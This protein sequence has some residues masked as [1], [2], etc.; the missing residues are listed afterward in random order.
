MYGIIFRCISVKRLKRDSRRACADRHFSTSAKMAD[1]DGSSPRRKSSESDRIHDQLA[2]MMNEI[3]SLKTQVNNQNVNDVNNRPAIEDGEVEDAGDGDFQDELHPPLDRRMRDMADLFQV[4]D[5][6]SEDEILQD[7]DNRTNENDLKGPPVRE[8]FQTIAQRRCFKKLDD[9]NLNQ[10]VNRALIPENVEL[11]TPRCNVEIWQNLH[12]KAKTIDSKLQQVQS[13][14]NRV[15]G[16]TMKCADELLNIRARTADVSRKRELQTEVE[17]SLDNANLLMHANVEISMR[18]RDAIC[19]RRRDAICSTF[20][21]PK[22]R[23]LASERVEL[24]DQLF[25]NDLSGALKSIDTCDRMGNQ[26]NMR[27]G[28]FNPYRGNKQ[29]NRSGREYHPYRQKGRDFGNNRPFVNKEFRGK[30]T[31]HLPKPSA[32]VSKPA[33]GK[34]NFTSCNDEFEGGRLS[35]HVENWKALT[36]DKFILNMI[37]GLK[38]DFHDEPQGCFKPNTVNRNEEQLINAEI[39]NLLQLKVIEKSFHEDGEIISPIFTRAKA[40]GSIRIILNLKKMNESVDKEHFKMES[41]ETVL[42]MVKHNCFMAS[43][44]LKHA[45][46]SLPIHPDYQKFLKFYWNGILYCYKV[47]PNGLSCGPRCFTKLMKPVFA[48][49]RLQ[50][51]LSSSFIDDIYLQGDSSAECENNVLNTKNLL[52]SLGFLVHKDKSEFKPKKQITF[53]GFMINS[54]DMTIKVT[55]ERADKVHN[56]CVHLLNETSW[57]IRSLA[58]V[59]GQIISCFPGTKWGPLFYRSLEN[60][61]IWALRKNKM[62]F[63]AKMYK[64]SKDAKSELIWWADNVHSNFKP[65]NKTKPDIFMETDSSNEGFGAKCMNT[66]INGRWS[67]D[68]KKNHINVLEMLAIFYALKAFDRQTK[69]DDKHIRISCDNTTAVAY[70]NNMGGSKSPACNKVAKDI[71]FWCMS[72]NIWISVVHLAGRLNTDADRES[73]HFNDDIEWKLNPKIFKLICQK[74]GQPDIDMFASRL[75]CQL[76]PFVS[77]KP[78]PECW[79]VDA[80]YVDWSQRFIY[81]FPPFSVIQRTL[82]KWEEDDAEGILIFPIWPTAAWFPQLLRLLVDYPVELPKQQTLLELVGTNLTHRLSHLRLAACH[83]SGNALKQSKFQTKLEILS[84]P[85]GENQHL[86]NM[87]PISKD[88]NYFVSKNRVIRLKHL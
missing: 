73:R 85:H 7:I 84:Y 72:R 35:K 53:L 69:L 21:N 27:R 18:R 80:F 74:F 28:G 4:H 48:T 11:V 36:N 61:K 59:I 16:N 65:I 17:R 46:Y 55:Q 62:N 38:I 10:V 82:R 9:N 50:G 66:C 39:N 22:T 83:L 1:S 68:E 40:D 15:V 23:R 26:I 45:Y 31:S 47:L 71:W 51:H 41:I 8:R 79:A 25:G 86:N 19:S 87:I 29:S 88:L 20:K 52:E 37:E 14:V 2:A 78:D 77:W 54:E 12:G 6:D 67:L 70:L 33:D 58:K 3:Q 43:I 57:T 42:S 63:D 5:A 64:L 75:N 56:S 76:R 32:T 44:D 81:C 30:R 49:L 13:L 34:S 60:D 24:T